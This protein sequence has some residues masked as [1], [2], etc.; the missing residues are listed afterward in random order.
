MTSKWTRRAAAQYGE[1]QRPVT[2]EVTAFA[3]NRSLTLPVLYRR[4]M[5]LVSSYRALLTSESEPA[6]VPRACDGDRASP[7]PPVVSGLRRNRRGHSSGGG[8][9]GPCAF[10]RACSWGRPVRRGRS[11]RM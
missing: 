6:A 1:R 10:L 11:G 7:F 4:V 3:R 5:L 8:H 2:Y 9:S